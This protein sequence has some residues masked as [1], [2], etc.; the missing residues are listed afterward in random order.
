MR[1]VGSLLAARSAEG[2][3]PFDEA[4]KARQLR[5]AEAG[6]LREA[7]ADAL[8]DRLD[9]LRARPLRV[10]LDVGG[11]A[12]PLLLRREGVERV[13]RLA[14]AG[15]PAPA[16]TRVRSV[17][18]GEAL[19]EPADAA[20]ALTGL[21]WRNDLAGSLAH[22]RAQLV[23]DA[24]CLGV[25]WGSGTVD[26]LR[27]ALLLAE[28]ERRGGVSRRCSPLAGP[29][30]VAK[31]LAAAGYTLTTLDSEVLALRYTDA[32]RALHDM[33]VL[34]EQCAAADR[35]AEAGAR[36]T[37]VAA[38]ALLQHLYRG[39]EGLDLQW[40]AVWWI[41]WT[42]SAR[43]PLPKRRGSQQFSLRELEQQGPGMKA[44][45]DRLAAEVDDE[46]AGSGD[47]Q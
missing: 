42:P 26:T 16:D 6:P 38:M 5:F 40:H 27:S 15:V 30:D 29:Q 43:Q 23:P 34:G 10:V 9:D 37:L 14:P 46:P 21:Q 35:G 17:G 32:A 8:G 11:W 18:W 36:S 28:L 47:K 2:A 4:V 45:R 19:P 31:A 33:R 25:L 20:V 3:L 22:V 44:L 12:T 1:R 13:Y 39:D 24:P 7:L 41:G